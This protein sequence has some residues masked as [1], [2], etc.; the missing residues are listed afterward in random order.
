MSSLFTQKMGELPNNIGSSIT[1]PTSFAMNLNDAESDSHSGQDSSSSSSSYFDG[2]NDDLHDGSHTALGVFIF[3]SLPVVYWVISYFFHIL[4]KKCCKIQLKPSLE[5]CCI[6]LDTYSYETPDNG[7]KGYENLIDQTWWVS[8]N[9]EEEEEEEEGGEKYRERKRNLNINISRRRGDDSGGA[10]SRGS[11]GLVDIGENMG[12]KTTTSIKTEEPSKNHT[13]ILFNDM[14]NDMNPQ[15]R[16]HFRKEL[17]NRYVYTPYEGRWISYTLKY[18]RSNGLTAVTSVIS[19]NFVIAFVALGLFALDLDP[20]TTLTL[21]GV[22][23]TALWFQGGLSEVFKNYL[24]YFLI[25]LTDKTHPGNIVNLPGYCDTDVC[26]V[27]VLPLY[28]VGIIRI[29]GKTVGD[30]VDEF[31]FVDIPNSVLFTLKMETVYR[32]IADHE[33]SGKKKVKISLH[34]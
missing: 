26:V 13:S 19:L 28:T 8:K 31:R 25:L 10:R 5:E 6:I 30:H 1:L 9:A 2:K 15:D 20:L 11:Y 21:S 32:W 4:E 14:E 7:F 18:I 22:T 33:K 27:E 12:G 24:Y 29:F 3:L 17:L 23:W 16:V 34:A